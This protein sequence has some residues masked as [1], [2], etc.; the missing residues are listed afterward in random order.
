MKRKYTSED[1]VRWVAKLNDGKMLADIAKEESTTVGT[2]SGTIYRARQRGDLPM[3]KREK[4]PKVDKAQKS[5]DGKPF[6][7][8]SGR[9]DMKRPEQDGPDIVALGNNQCKFPVTYDRPYK[10]CGAEKTH[11]P[12]CKHHTRLARDS[13]PAN[14]AS[15]DNVVKWLTPA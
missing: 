13:S 1:A 5:E 2:I 12:Y 6:I 15:I 7:K 8:A 4:R 10:F 11:G 3:V 9:P 14:A